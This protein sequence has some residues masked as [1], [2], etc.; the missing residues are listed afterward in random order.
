MNP[1]HHGPS[2]RAILKSAVAA[3]VAAGVAPVLRAATPASEPARGGG[4]DVGAARQRN[5]VLWYRQPAE[6]WVEALPVG[7]GRIGGMV[8]GGVDAEHVALNDNT[9][10]S[11]EPGSR[12]LPQLDVTK[13]FDE[14]VQQLRDAKYAEV[15]AYVSKHWLGRQ[16]ESYQPLGDLTLE[17]QKG[18]KA[19]EY[20]RELDLATAV[21]RTTYQQNGITFTRECFASFPDRALVMQLTADKPG[22]ISFTTKLSSVHPTAKSSPAGNDTLVMTGQVPGL[23]SHRS[24]SWME[25]R[26]E[27][28]KYPEL[29]DA[30]GKRKP[31]AKEV[32]YGSEIGGLGT[33]FETRVHVRADGGEVKAGDN[34]LS[35]RNADRVL[36]ILATGSSYNGFD[37]SPSKQGADPSAQAKDA[38]SAA[39]GKSFEQLRDAHVTDYRALFDRVTLDLAAPTERS[40]LPTDERI[41]KY[42]GG[43]DESLAAMFFQ[44]GRYLMIAGSRA[45]GQP[46]NLQGI[47]NDKVTPPW[48]SAY[49]TN[50]NTE[51]NYWPVEVTNLSEC[52]EPLMR[53]VREL[54]IDGAKTAKQMYH[55]PGWVF[56]HNTTIWRDTQPVD[57]DAKACFWPMGAGWL[58][59][60]LWEHYLFTR[61]EK[62][63]REHAY[64][65][66]KSA[67]EF[68]VAWLID[69]GNGHLVTPVGTSPENNFKYTDSS[70]KEKTGAL[71]MGP[72]MDIAITRDLFGH[73]IAAAEVL[74]T[75]SEF[76][77]LLKQKREKLLPYQIGSRGNIQEWPKDFQDADPHHRHV[78]H[79]FGLYP[80]NQITISATPE[81]F[82]AARKTL[83]LRGDE[84][85]GWSMGWKINFWARLLDG[86]HAHKLITDLIRPAGGTDVVMHGGGTYPNL[87]DAHPPFQIDGN[88]GATAG[89]AE[90]LLQSHAGSVDLLPALPKAWPDGKVTGLKARGGF[91][92]DIEWSDGKLA[93][94]RVRSLAGQPLKLRSAG[95]LEARVDDQPVS[96]QKREDPRTVAFPTQ[97][98][99]TYRVRSAW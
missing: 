57:G 34:D 49:T 48:A 50:I 73:C 20:R 62:F 19:A 32:L 36:L 15:Q 46:L 59:R 12:D 33:F 4:D 96:D 21:A 94:A 30:D 13:D 24:L 76:A 14:V 83:E 41:K 2:R 37:K 5:L 98:G 81:L 25:S 27:T 93:E 9:L 26:G 17:F 71:C 18:E 40:K 39:S 67:A 95:P 85:T 55:R 3:A 22:S 99:K 42:A 68:L 74:K 78:S 23:A 58:S 8:F 97:Q 91:E 72:T 29:F 54:S 47:W 44:F 88:F 43:G 31:G 38:M 92:V 52:A 60:H 79:L 65:V 64:P 16:Q 61:D 66:M 69:D 56:H 51:M 6:K 89:I 70:G 87:F 90:M 10:Y 75:D 77:Q 35:V 86:D 1:S 28:W 84:A 80:A 45:G 11:G 53:M 7:N 63:L 82:A